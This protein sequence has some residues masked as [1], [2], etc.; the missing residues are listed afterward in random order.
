MI[1]VSVQYS[2]SI[3][4][5]IILHLKL[6]QN[7]G[8]IPCAVHYILV[9]YLFYIQQFVSLNLYPCLAS[10]PSFSPLV[11]TSFFS[12][13]LFLFCC[14]RL[15][16]LFFQFHIQVIILVFFSLTY[17]TSATLSKS[18]HVVTNGRISFFLTVEQ[19]SS[20]CVC[21]CVCVCV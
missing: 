12:V 19:Y 1:L 3:Y 7:N 2:D 4:L 6:L 10:P 15:F 16:V 18:I 13:C 17:F 11:T 20:V 14:V 8:Y 21:V 5:K 9:A